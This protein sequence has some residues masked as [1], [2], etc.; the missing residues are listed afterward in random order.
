MSAPPLSG[1]L[2]Q[3]DPSLADALPSDPPPLSASCPSD[4]PLPVPG[5]GAESPEA[6]LLATFAQALSDVAP[7]Q[8][9]ARALPAP[10]R[11]RTIVVGAG[12]AAA[13]MAQALEHAWPGE[14]SGLVVTRYG[15]GL[16]CERIQVLEAAHP[17]PDELGLDAARQVMSLV[18]GLSP[19]DLVIA[20]FSGGGS[21]LLPLPAEGVTIEDK[22]SLT[23]QLLRAGATISEINCL[24]KH[25]SA[26]KGGR[27][28][29]ASAPARLLN[30]LISDVAGDD[31]SAIASGPGVPDPSTL[32]DAREVLEKYGLE[33]SDAVLEHLSDPSS[34]TPKPGDPCFERVTT[35]I[36]SCSQA[37]LES[38]A[39]FLSSKGVRPVILSDSIEGE[40]RDV[41]LVHAA[42][43]RQIAHHDQPAVAPCVILSGGETTVTLRGSGS[44]GPNAEF[45][46]ALVLALG[47]D[48]DY[49]AIACDTD[50]VDG[51]SEV[52][53]AIACTD[54]L[55]RARAA[56]LDARHF[57][58][59]NDSHSFFH[60]L[61]D[62]VVTGPTY[63]NVNDFRAVFVLPS[64]DR[65]SSG[66]KK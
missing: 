58:R 1:D 5:S 32:A 53:G 4:R 20:L 24:R 37:L 40:S 42:I 22:Q 47:K 35:R 60:A 23:S 31:P 38:A 49:A 43:A 9:L 55:A 28:A 56:G 19:D 45:L 16:P 33:A 15:Y 62:Q 39:A 57:L 41:A 30:L 51:V 12:K 52:A 50:G 13:S 36:I 21:A 59:T 8:V 10:P 34:E 6:L 14:L 29:Q 25:L 7:E 66:H 2:P 65:G 64:A 63:N 18:A 17:V 44:G 61:G 27:L 46:L 54:T 11:G 48:V 3:R 26:I